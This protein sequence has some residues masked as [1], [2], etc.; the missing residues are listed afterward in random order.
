MTNPSNLPNSA[1][2]S[3]A[4]ASVSEEDRGKILQ[5]GGEELLLEKVDDRFTVHAGSGQQAR[6]LANQF[7]ATIAPGTAPPEL[8][9]F[10]VDPAQK[11]QVLN[12]VRQDHN[13]EY[14]SHVYQVKNSPA[15]RIYLTN[16]ITIQF[17]P[18]VSAETIAAI[19][20]ELG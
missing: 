10:V 19:T 12:E 9:E 6:D 7:P 14:A 18:T 20:S 13:V 2:N 1:Q 15:S 5:R 11:D 17:T 8:T 3:P 16:Q 4:N